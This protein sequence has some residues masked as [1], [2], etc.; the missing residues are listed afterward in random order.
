MTTDMYPACGRGREDIALHVTQQAACEPVLCPANLGAAL[1]STG[2]G[3]ENRLG[4][5]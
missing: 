3:L 4:L 1:S 5:P 2:V